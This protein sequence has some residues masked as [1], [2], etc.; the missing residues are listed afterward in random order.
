MMLGNLLF[1]TAQC[2]G[3][4]ESVVDGATAWTWEQTLSR[5][6]QRAGALKGARRV[7]VLAHNSADYLEL[8]FAAAMAGVALVP[9]NTRLATPELHALLTDAAPDMLFTDA[10]HQVVADDIVRAIGGCEVRTLPE[11]PTAAEA[12]P[13]D[14][15]DEAD[16]A[17]I[18]TGGTTGLPK[19][20][21]VTRRG[22]AFNLGHILRDLDWGHR[23]RF[24]QTTPLFHLAA[25]GPAW[26][27]AAWGGSQRFLHP[28]SIDA[29][30]DAIERDRIEA[31]AL[32][33]TMIGWLVGRD[34][35]GARDLS[36]LCAIGYGASAIPAA[37]LAKAL[38]AFPG[39]KFNQFYGQTEASGGLATLGAADHAQHL[40]AAGRPVV[41]VRLEIRDADD[42]LAPPGTWGEICAKTPG[43]FAGYLNNPEATAEATRG[44]WLRTGDV[45]FIDANGFLHVTDRIKDMIVT[46]GENVS[47][48]EVESAITRHPAVHE[49]AVVA[50]PDPDWGE[51]VHAVVRLRDG[52]SLD[53]AAL[54]AHCRAH[55]AAYKCPKTSEISEAPLPLSAVG[56]I[57]KDALRERA[58]RG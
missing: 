7:A 14:A 49:V 10:A 9:M 47:S 16:W 48:S 37:V 36:S 52:A 31:T 38:A 53:H 40:T 15:N 42:R 54:V 12:E 8:S 17:I 18:Y 50:A 5:V 22:F 32:V 11:E 26:A 35:L 58:R 55:I 34:D 6:R 13:T 24:L 39:L 1:R 21:R 43:L 33:P 20:V 57:R 29:L 41:G 30:V 44:G 45:G 27:V 56:K 2:H 19:G 4:A 23:P 46:G 28:F 25:L 3:T 51:R